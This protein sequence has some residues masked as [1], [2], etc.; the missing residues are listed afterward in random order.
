MTTRG[1]LLIGNIVSGV[2]RG[3][4]RSALVLATGS[5]FFFTSGKSQLVIGTNEAEAEVLDGL[6]DADAGFLRLP[7]T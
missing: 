4:A 3:Q 7:L 1:V 2:G 6:A 5:N